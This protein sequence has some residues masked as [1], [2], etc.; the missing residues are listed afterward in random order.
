MFCEKCGKDNLDGAKF[1]E[2]CGA[3]L[4]TEEVAVSEAT[5]EALDEILEQVDN[6]ATVG[7]YE[8]YEAEEAPAPAPNN[9]HKLIK[10]GI[11]IVALIVAIF[12]IVKI[13]SCAIHCGP[14]GPIKAEMKLLNN[15]DI[16]DKDVEKYLKTLP[17]EILEIR[18]GDKKES[19]YVDDLVE[20]YEDQRDELEDE[21]GSNV[22][23]SFDIV[24]R[25]KLTDEEIKDIEEYY[26]DM[27]DE[28]IDVK[29]GYKY[30]LRVTA[31]GKKDKDE[32]FDQVTVIKVDG[33]W[34]VDESDYLV[35]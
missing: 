31:K 9:T 19:E 23:V 11:V 1:C 25:K 26:K 10:L 16:K 20:S 18:R 24:D 22:K 8:S 27:Y 6:D 2:A 30:L 21:Y 7:G 13:S 14:T 3:P 17:E 12:C 5:E 35:Y 34:I 4:E 28:K 15:K 33:K 32:Y 29:K